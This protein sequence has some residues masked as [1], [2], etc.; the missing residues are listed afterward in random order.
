MQPEPNGA[1]LADAGLARWVTDVR[2]SSGPGCRA[3]G[4]MSLRAAARER[5]A[6]RPPGPALSD[7]RDLRTDAGLR[8]RLYRPTRETRPTVVYLH[9][10][11]FVMGDLDTHDGICRTLAHVADVTV[12]SVDF[13]LAPE[14]PAP[15]AVED[16]AHAVRCIDRHLD[17]LGGDRAGGVALAGDSSGATTAILTAVHLC[18]DG[19]RPSALLLA[20]PN[21]DMTLSEPSVG[22]EG[23]GWGLDAEDLRWFVEQW[24]PDPDQ[25]SDPE[26]SPLH[27]DAGD[28]VRLPPTVLATAEHDPLRDEGEALARRLDAL[29]VLVE[30]RT[31]P[32]LVHGFLGLGHVSTAA[33]EAGRAL[34]RRFGQRLRDLQV[35][36]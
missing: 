17:R 22:S 20:Y 14:H 11:G 34:F 12:V 10:G 8:L 26:V 13:R 27:A 24:V 31:H 18:A 6:S 33:G 36:G 30:H 5:A 29:G 32:G 7:V 2:G 4:A 19:Q 3:L 21:A 35:P 28:L 23:R 25:R 15:T 1:D 9:G 16:A